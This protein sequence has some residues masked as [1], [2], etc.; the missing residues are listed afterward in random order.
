MTLPEIHTLFA[1]EICQYIKYLPLDVQNVTECYRML[2]NVTECY[3]M[4]QNV[5]ILRFSQRECKE[6]L[7]GLGLKDQEERGYVSYLLLIP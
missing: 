3:R 5:D 2:Q 6:N 7:A 1:C 4:L